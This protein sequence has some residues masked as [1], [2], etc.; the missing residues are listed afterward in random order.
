VDIW[1]VS[2]QQASSHIFFKRFYKNMINP[3]TIALALGIVVLLS[4]IILPKVVKDTIYGIGGT[5]QNTFYDI[6]RAALNYIDHRV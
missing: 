1:S 4:G 6:L 5:R 2:L 3:T